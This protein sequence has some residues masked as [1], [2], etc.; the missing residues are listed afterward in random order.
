M[1]KANLVRPNLILV[2]CT[3]GDA[4]L[5]FEICKNLGADAYVE[6]PL[7][8]EKISEIVASLEDKLL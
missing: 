8:I 2:I 4:K 3:A 6:K 1:K 5:E 7:K